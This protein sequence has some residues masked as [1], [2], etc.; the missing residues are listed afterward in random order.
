MAGEKLVELMKTAAIGAVENKSMADILF[1]EVTSEKPLKVKVDNRF[2]L[3][4]SFLIVP[5]NLTDYT[6]TVMIDNRTEIDLIR[7]IGHI[8]S[9]PAGDSGSALDIN[10]DHSHAYKGDKK[11]II[12]NGLK[13]GEKVI[14]LRAI[15]GQKYYILDKVVVNK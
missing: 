14:L 2:E 9:T 6:V 1:G 3:D 13:T 8:H 15:G 10:L 7:N 4:E 5:R 12:K 11:Y